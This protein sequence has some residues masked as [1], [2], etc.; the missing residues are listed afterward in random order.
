M[1]EQSLLDNSFDAI[2]FTKNYWFGGQ[3]DVF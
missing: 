3:A 2:L 1:L